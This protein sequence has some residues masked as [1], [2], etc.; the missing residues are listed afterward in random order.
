MIIAI[1]VS[2]ICLVAGGYGLYQVAFARGYVDGYEDGTG[3]IVMTIVGD[4][5]KI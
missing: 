4:D 5:G 2:T 1:C 3:E